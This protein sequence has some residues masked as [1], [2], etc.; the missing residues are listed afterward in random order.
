MKEM[1]MCQIVNENGVPANDYIYT[2]LEL[3]EEMCNNLVENYNEYYT[4]RILTQYVGDV[5][6]NDVYCTHGS[7]HN[8]MVISTD[9]TV[10]CTNCGLRNSLSEKK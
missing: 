6:A 8:Y 5:V 9:G 7:K 2:D 10:E 4:V 3:A 1:M